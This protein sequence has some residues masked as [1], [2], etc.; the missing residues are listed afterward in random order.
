MEIGTTIQTHYGNATVDV[1]RYPKGGAIYIQLYTR[2]EGFPEPLIT[3]ST[4]ILAVGP[5]LG[6]DEFCVKDWSENEAFI[7]AVYASGLFE[8]T[9]RLVPSGYVVAPVWRLKQA[10][11]V[12]ELP[13]HLKRKMASTKAA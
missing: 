10:E 2:E 9:G 11:H 4:N 13:S 12:P 3:L 8:R 7:D 6:L 1:G 5:N